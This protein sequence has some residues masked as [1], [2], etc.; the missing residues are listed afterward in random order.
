M[1]SGLL[2]GVM[3][4]LNEVIAPSGVMRP[5]WL[6]SV[7]ENQ[8]LPSGPAIIASGPAFG[9]GRGNSVIVPPVVMR[10]ILLPVFS[11]NQNAPSG[12]SMMPIGVAFGVGRSNSVNAYVLGSSRPIFEAPLSQNH[13]QPSRPS[14]AI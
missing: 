8:M 14:T 4:S 3:P 7:C 12:P 9:V 1:E 2:P 13:R 11:A 5:I 10:P 6:T